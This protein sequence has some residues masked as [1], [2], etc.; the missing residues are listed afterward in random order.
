MF[1]DTSLETYLKQSSTVG[2]RP[3]IIAEWNLND[4]ENIKNYGS[5]RYRPSDTSS[6]YAFLPT[7]YQEVDSMNAYTNSLDSE[8]LVSSIL[9]E[10]NQPLFY[11][12]PDERKS[13][14][15][16]LKDCFDPFRPRSGINRPLYFSNS[17]IDNISSA[18]RPR[19]YLSSRKDVFKYWNSYKKEVLISGSTQFIKEFG[20]SESTLEF[21][22]ISQGYRIEDVAPFVVYKKEFPANRIIVKMQTN[23]AD[24]EAALPSIRKKTDEVIQDPYLDINN[25]TIPVIWDI[26][27]LDKDNRWVTAIS[28]D[29]NSVRIDNSRIVDWDGYVEIYYGLKV[30]NRYAQSFNLV[31]Y[32][33][34]T[35]QL[36]SNPS[37]GEAYIIGASESDAGLLYIWNGEVNEWESGEATY[38]FSLYETDDTKRIGLV[39]KLTDPD[40][41][42]VNGE[43]TYREF[44]YIKG[45]RVVVKNMYA[46][47]KTFDLIEMSPRLRAD[48]TEYTSSYDVSKSLANPSYGI[49]VGGLTPSNGTIT[50]YNHDSAFSEENTLIDDQGSLLA[51]IE[52]DPQNEPGRYLSLLKP[53]VKFDFYEAITQVEDNGLIYDKFVPIKT[54]YSE[55]FPLIAGGTQDINIELRDAY[56]RFE[57]TIAPSLFLKNVTLT[58]AV[59]VMLDNIGFSNYVFLN[60]VNNIKYDPVIEYF[61][62]EPN[63]TVAEVLQRLAVATQA[64]MFF[65]EYNNFVIMVKEYLIPNQNDRD[66]DW[67]MYGQISSASV[68]PFNPQ[69]VAKINDYALPNIVRIN[70]AETFIVNDGKIDYKARYIQRSA[71]TTSQT[72]FLGDDRTYIYKPVLL[73]EVGN[74]EITRTVN[75]IAKQSKY[76]LGA[77]PLNSKLSNSVPTVV[78]HE[79]INNIIDLG[80][81]VYWLPRFQGYLYANGEIIRYDAVEYDVSGTGRVWIKNNQ[82]YQKYFGRLPFNGKIYP[83][84]NVRI[85]VEPYYEELQDTSLVGIVGTEKS[86]RPR[87]GEV[88]SH[89]RGQFNTSVAEHSAGISEEW[90][91][92]SYVGG[93]SMRSEYLFN[94]IPPVI[95]RNDIFGEPIFPQYYQENSSLGIPKTSLTIPTIL[96]NPSLSYGVNDTFAKNSIRR[97][98]IANFM[99]SNVPIENLNNKDSATKLGVVQSSALVFNGPTFTGSGSA[100]AARDFVTMVHKDFAPTYV[101][102]D[103]E[104]AYTGVITPLIV[105]RLKTKPRYRHFGTRMRI[106]GKKETNGSNQTPN[107][108]IQYFSVTNTGESSKVNLSGGSGGISV[109]LNPETKQG[110]Y[111][112]ISSLTSTDLQQYTLSDDATGLLNQVIHNIIFYK[113]TPGRVGSTNV[114][115]PVKLWGGLSNILVD[116]GKFTGQNRIENP[117]YPT[118][119]DL[120]VE[121]DV[122]NSGQNPI[123]RFNLYINNKLIATV[124]D[125]KPINLGTAMGLFVRGSSNCMFENVYAINN[126]LS[127]KEN[128]PL[129]ETKETSSTPNTITQIDSI[130]S[131]QTIPDLVKDTYISS[132]DTNGPKKFDMYFEE[133]GTIMRECAYFNIKY[134]KAYPAFL[135]KLAP[136]LSTERT[137]TVSQFYAGSYGAEFM[138]FNTADR[139]IVLDETSGNFL[140]ILGVTFTQD[141]AYSLTVDDH[142]KKISDFS[143]AVR[144]DNLFKSPVVQRK[145]FDEILSSRSKYGKKNFAL[146][147][148]YIQNQDQASD[149]MDWLVSKTLRPRK[150]VYIDAFATQHLQLGDIVNIDYELPDGYQF[151]DK[152]KKFVISEITYNRSMDGPTMNIKAVEI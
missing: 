106:I 43:K 95:K 149:L 8:D 6:I 5:Y 102:K 121:Y 11:K 12:R 7:Q 41:F 145:V 23:M 63:I 107:N 76:T 130:S 85:F 31:E 96:N 1:R 51:K 64:A 3:L 79:V 129:Y 46:P 9:D 54:M 27:Y 65:D 120:A 135:A 103:T 50:I 144:V 109:L 119:Y 101:Y 90:T 89:G 44:V 82:E 59:A 111:F 75:E 148:D 20:I 140:R 136:T 28:F 52:I 105:P 34:S 18:R 137:Y 25:S 33:T 61:F 83:T 139:Y 24:P 99:R 72:E 113:V 48:I 66:I 60:T 147:S 152:N 151:V 138:I 91:S 150:I 36:P 100:T 84:G 127:S 126:T 49:P 22:G 47:R 86:V 30:S 104:L 142:F 15:F 108:A 19:Y 13:L 88:K 55:N 73:W 122:I 123:L 81:N 93:V 78:N 131:K 80:E 37:H 146:T 32:F 58:A 124:Y 40:F 53:N 4:V 143:N 38:G 117:E 42:I 57:T 112:E 125:D 70:N 134:D 115:L 29:A 92:N 87:N 16:S 128:K 141:T 69:V 77:V 10:N 71:A 133:F 35:D 39:K 2:I 110:Y 26:E 98:T 68:T 45:L 56:F 94:T 14:Y 118:V 17:Y 116:E 132:I 21:T 114:A 74:Q 62:V 67:T 97:G